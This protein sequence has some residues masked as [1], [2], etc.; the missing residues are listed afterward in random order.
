MLLIVILLPVLVM[1]H[2][3]TGFQN[4]F[5]VVRLPCNALLYFKQSPHGAT[6]LPARISEYD[7]AL[8]TSETGQ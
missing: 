8:L 7:E 6:E 3:N 1:N 2:Y 5:F 4:G